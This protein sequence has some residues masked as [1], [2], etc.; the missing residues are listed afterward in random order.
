M[1]RLF[2]VGADD[3]D[4]LAL[5]FDRATGLGAN[6]ARRLGWSLSTTILRG[7][8]ILIG[9]PLVIDGEASV[10]LGVDMVVLWM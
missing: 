5:E 3:D 10:R 7:L 1:E 4:D 8:L 6:S 9:L 2:G